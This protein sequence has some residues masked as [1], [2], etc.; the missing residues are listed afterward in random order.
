MQRCPYPLSVVKLQPKHA[1]KNVLNLFFCHP[2][3]L[4]MKNT[5][6]RQKASSDAGVR[7]FFFFFSWQT[8]IAIKVFSLYFHNG[9]SRRVS[10]PP[11]EQET[12]WKQLNIPLPLIFPKCFLYLGMD[13]SSSVVGRHLL[14]IALALLY[15][16]P[17]SPGVQHGDLGGLGK[18]LGLRA[19][20]GQAFLTTG[21]IPYVKM[22]PWGFL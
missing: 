22:R 4:F 16:P 9:I 13:R 8:I 1:S 20:R 14:F 10:P 6:K 7:L 11:K 18:G 17:F 19:A 2:L 12:T 21:L 5:N 15:P 3:L